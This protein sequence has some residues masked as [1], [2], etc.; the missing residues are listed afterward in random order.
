[1]KNDENKAAVVC[2]AWSITFIVGMFM[3]AILNKPFGITL[4]IVSTLILIIYLRADGR[5][6]AEKKRRKLYEQDCERRAEEARRR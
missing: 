6:E 1:M 4:M 5:I 3:A 2:I